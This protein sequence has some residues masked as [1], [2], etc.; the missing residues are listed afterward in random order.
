MIT[1]RF[2]NVFFKAGY[3]QQA[4]G[5]NLLKN[6]T[7][8]Q[9]A[10]SKTSICT[11]VKLFFRALDTWIALMAQ[12]SIP[13]PKSE[14]SE[15]IRMLP[16][17][18]K[19]LDVMEILVSTKNINPINEYIINEVNSELEKHIQRIQTGKW[20]ETMS[21]F[22]L[23]GCS[24]MLF[25]RYLFNLPTYAKAHIIVTL[26]TMVAITVVSMIFSIPF[27]MT[28]RLNLFLTLVLVLF[29]VIQPSFWVPSLNKMFKNQSPN[30]DPEG[31]E[32]V[33]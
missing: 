26:L 32:L 28:I 2:Q 19:S 14:R 20:E 18:Q 17:L 5:M 4:L 7:A 27:A 21:E 30:D 11:Q 6:C 25:K 15:W 12:N 10:K 31:V 1:E 33:D 13:I 23:L 22:P 16:R 8:K 29:Y 3:V 24:F 9:C